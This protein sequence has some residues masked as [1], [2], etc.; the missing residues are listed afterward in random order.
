MHFGVHVDHGIVM[1]HCFNIKLVSNTIE[2]YLPCQR[3]DSPSM[4]RSLG[5][6]FVMVNEG[7]ITSLC[8][9]LVRAQIQLIHVNA[10]K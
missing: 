4:R 1:V 2:P 10:Y 9:P 6:R 5:K 7:F 8:N 3:G